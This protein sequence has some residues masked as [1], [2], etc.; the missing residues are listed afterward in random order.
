MPLNPSRTETIR[1]TAVAK[2][3]GTIVVATEHESGHD[4]A[5]TFNADCTTTTLQDGTVVVSWDTPTE[6]L[7]RACVSVQGEVIAMRSAIPTA[8]GLPGGTYCQEACASVDH[9]DTSASPL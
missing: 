9:E 7:I 5:R 3:D 2:P 4:A 1:I 6:R 8:L